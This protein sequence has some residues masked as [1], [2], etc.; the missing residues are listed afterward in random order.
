[1]RS[2]RDWSSDV[3]SSDLVLQ[4]ESRP[5]ISHEG[6]DRVGGYLNI[7]GHRRGAVF[8]RVADGPA[9]CAQQRAARFGPVA[10]QVYVADDNG[11]NVGGEAVFNFGGDLVDRGGKRAGGLLSIAKEPHAQFALLRPREP[12]YCFGVTGAHLD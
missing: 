2:K 5:A 10:S 3:C 4:T 8:E 11:V 1:P 12:G 7:N 6:V 9:Q